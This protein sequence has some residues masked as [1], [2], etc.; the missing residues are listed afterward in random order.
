MRLHVGTLLLVVAAVVLAVA[1]VLPPVHRGREPVSRVA[2][3]NHLMQ[4]AVYCL[5]YAEA[6]EKRFP[7]DAGPNPTAVGTF[8]ALIDSRTDF[9]PRCLVSPA[10][11]DEPARPDPRGRLRL[12]PKNVSYA[13]LSPG[14][15]STGNAS[16]VL[17]ANDTYRGAPNQEGEPEG[18][19]DGVNTVLVSGEAAWLPATRL[20]EGRSFPAGL[21]DGLG[22]TQ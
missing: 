9:D 14:G 16:A 10:Q 19:H 8:Q 18:H 5:S 15:R 22:R 4:L 20:G 21:I 2:C 12:G 3:R 6:H 7:A 1:A 13:I 11:R 17:V